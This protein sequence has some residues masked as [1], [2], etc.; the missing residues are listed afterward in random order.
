MNATTVTRTAALLSS[1]E[2]NVKSL[3]E[4][5]SAS[6]PDDEFSRLAKL[7]ADIRGARLLVESMR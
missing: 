4:G 2:D 5:L 3:V 7:L 1:A 6:A